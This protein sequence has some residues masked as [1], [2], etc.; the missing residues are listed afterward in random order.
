MLDRHGRMRPAWE[1]LALQ[2]TRWSLQDREALLASSKRMIDD[3]GTTF[4]VYR[5]V[6]G[7][8][9]QPYELDP[10]PLVIPKEDWGRVSAGLAQRLRVLE[11]I[12]ADLYGPQNLLREGL[13]PP[14]LVHA[15][16]AFRQNIRHIQPAG[17]RFLVSSGCDLIRTPEGI[18]TVLRDHTVV[19]GGL[20]QALENRIV[21]SNI[22]P[23]TFESAQVARLSPFFD[24]ERATLHALSPSRS[25]VP[26]V[27][28]LTP[29]FRHPSYFEHAYKARLLG[30]PL[31]ESADLTVRERRLYLKTL[32]GLHRIDGVLCRLED[33]SLDPLEFWKVAGGGVPGLVQAWRS[34]NVALANAPGSGFATS[35]ALLPFLPAICKAVLGEPLKLPFVETWWLGQASVRRRVLEELPRYVLLSAFRSDPLLPL[36]CS[37]LSPNSRRQWTAAIEQRPHDFVVQLDVKPSVMPSLQTRALQDRPV[38]W[39]A[40]TLN[41]PEAPYALPGGLARVGK[42][43]EPPQLW[44]AHAGFTKDVWVTGEAQEAPEQLAPRVRRGLAPRHPSAL[45]VPSRIAEQLFWVGRYSERLELVTRLLRVTLRNLSGEAGRPHEARLAACLILA[46]GCGVAL[47]KPEEEPTPLSS[48]PALT[49]L[50]HDSTI[51]S[52]L[53]RL[54]RSLLVNAAAARDRLSD[55]TWRFFNR[56]ESIVHT[57]E[58]PPRSSE[59]LRT[60]DN[61][62]LHLAAFSGMQAENMTRGQGWRFLETGRRLERAVGGLSLLQSAAQPATVGIPVLDPLLEICD[63]VMTYR[64]RH[65]SRPQWDG[66]ID[67]ILFDLANPRSVAFQIDIIFSELGR[68]PG[69]HG[70]GLFPQITESIRSIAARFQSGSVPEESELGDLGESFET[71][72]DLLTQHYFSHAIRRVY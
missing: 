27:V 38:V 7:G 22:L 61:L 18:W 19:P 37:T 53:A 40:F 50:V 21:S 64:R 3:L 68:F 33:E 29:G 70:S 72:S 11:A 32:S 52:G 9:G 56:L 4:N 55:D 23:D 42:P 12:L 48:L 17:G 16:P 28:F 8:G 2:V 20:G 67:L 25:Q 54:T 39:R 26:N 30:F 59:L 63:S 49:R 62:V 45:E 71:L 24:L 51:H 43:G 10:I 46:D 15:N 58:I 69:D 66:V 60:L 6:G 31:V 65:F 13:L 14:D 34:A 57:P 44:P 35:P 41:A 1:N 36:R 47:G 5:D